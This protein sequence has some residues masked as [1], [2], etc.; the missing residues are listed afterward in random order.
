MKTPDNLE[1][2][3]KKLHTLVF[4]A[5]EDVPCGQ[6]LASLM[7][8]QRMLTDS[9]LSDIEEESEKMEDESPSLL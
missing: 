7:L 6:R 3:F 9:I 5:N 1:V 8:V 4:D 2:F